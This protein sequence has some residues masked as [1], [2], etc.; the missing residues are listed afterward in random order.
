MPEAIKHLVDSQALSRD[1]VENFFQETRSMEETVRNGSQ[2]SPDN[3]MGI[4]IFDEPSNITLAS[5]QR[6]CG[7][8]RWSLA[9]REA[10]E[11][12]M[13]EGHP[14]E[15]I[16]VL[17]ALGYDFIILRSGKAGYAK[18]AAEHSQVPI[19]NAGESFTHNQL[20]YPTQHPTQALADMYTA[21]KHHG[22]IDDLT[23]DF[24]GELRAN[25]VVNSMLYTLSNFKVRII[26]ASK[27]GSYNIPLAVEA[28]LD[29]RNIQW[30]KTPDFH[31]H[32]HE[33]DM[34]YFAPPHH[35]QRPDAYQ[36]SIGEK[37]LN[38]LRPNSVM[39]H[40]LLRGTTP[41]PI[42]DP[43]LMWRLQIENGVYARMAMLKMLVSS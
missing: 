40:D 21:Y 39:L 12:S 33:A 28:H 7:H 9:T 10:P 34:I 38:L 18:E 42:D 20:P 37:E 15:E 5:F 36:D 1:W 22:H 43:R 4:A 27:G 32:L 26:L 6:A 2:F 13:W 16:E 35:Q 14:Q 29:D 23:I 3:R 41:Q 24:V 30:V 8:L 25:A 19:I 17:N 11:R 31:D